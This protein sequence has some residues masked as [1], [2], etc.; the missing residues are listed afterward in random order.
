[1]KFFTLLLRKLDKKIFQMEKNVEII[2]LSDFFLLPV[3][4]FLKKLFFI[5]LVNLNPK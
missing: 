5:E 3:Q 1:M 4:F 2:T